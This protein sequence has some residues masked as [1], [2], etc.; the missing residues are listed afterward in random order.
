VEV[1]AQVRVAHVQDGAQLARLPRRVREDELQLMMPMLLV[2]LRMRLFLIDLRRS[3]MVAIAP[4]R[5]VLV[6]QA[7]GRRVGARRAVWLPKGG[8]TTGGVAG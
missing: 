2:L 6:R 4:Q 1:V 8:R 7:D 3:T 5:L